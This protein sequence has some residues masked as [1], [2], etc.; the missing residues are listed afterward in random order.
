MEAQTQDGSSRVGAVTEQRPS[1]SKELGAGFAWVIVELAPDGILVSD[2]DG[3]I[4]LANRRAE[5]MFGYDQ[6]ELLGARVE[7][8]LPVALRAVHRLHRS[9]YAEAPTTRPMGSGIEL[10]ALRAD[11]TELPVEISLSAVAADHGPVPIVVVRELQRQPVDDREMRQICVSAE[12][13]DDHSHDQVITQLFG[14]G[15][16]VASVLS[17]GSL[18]ERLARRLHDV[19]DQL[20]GAIHDL[21]Q[22]MF[23]EPRSAPEPA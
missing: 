1:P 19:L 22:L 7:N 18:D 6:D 13:F 5:S 15:L 3:V 17:D 9:R 21:R 2:D 4:V 12:D 10:R 16:T 11:G 23:A 8:L 20:D 14:S